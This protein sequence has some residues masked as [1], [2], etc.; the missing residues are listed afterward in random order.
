MEVEYTKINKIHEVNNCMCHNYYYIY[1]GR[2]INAEKTK[3]KKFKYILWFDIF[4][5]QEYYNKDTITKDDIKQYANELCCDVVENYVK[6]YNDTEGL[7][8]FYSWCKETIENYNRI[9]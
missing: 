8:A 3:Y 2:I 9:D 7:K 6:D 5:L 1:Y 4:D